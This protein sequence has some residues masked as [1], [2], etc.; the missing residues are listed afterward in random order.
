MLSMPIPTAK[1][2]AIHLTDVMLEYSGVLEALLGVVYSLDMKFVQ[3]IV[4]ASLVLDLAEKWDFLHVRPLI[5][6]K[7]LQSTFSANN[8]PVADEF[9]LSLK[10]RDPKLASAVLLEHFDIR[11]AVP[12]EEQ[13]DSLP[14]SSCDVQRRYDERSPDLNN[15]FQYGSVGEKIFE[16]GTWGYDRFL[17]T[18]P[19]A[20]WSLLHAMHVGTT[21][22]AKYDEDKVSKEFER[23]LTLA[24]KSQQLE[25]S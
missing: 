11:W 23:V 17:R 24:C 25:Y 20:V 16:L 14:F 5:S 10:L 22:R 4:R 15:A 7:V 8:T 3:D 18:P 1:R 9:E 6:G 2:D 12:S 19:T 21:Q 13:E